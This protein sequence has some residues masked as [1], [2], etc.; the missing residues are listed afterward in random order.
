MNFDGDRITNKRLSA[1]KAL[2]FV[3]EKLSSS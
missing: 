2:E 1:E 3:L